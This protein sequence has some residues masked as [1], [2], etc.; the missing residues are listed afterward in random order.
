MKRSIANITRASILGL[1]AL[2]LF[3]LGLFA[4][5]AEILSGPPSGIQGDGPAAGKGQ[6]LISLGPQAEGARTFIPA[7]DYGKLDT[8]LTKVNINALLVLWK[9]IR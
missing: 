5:R 2:G 8:L 7:G 9:N 1:L 6:V 4:G 3:T